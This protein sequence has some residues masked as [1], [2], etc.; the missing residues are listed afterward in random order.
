METPYYKASPVM[1]IPIEV[2]PPNWIKF[3]EKNS[4]IDLI[5]PFVN[6]YNDRSEAFDGEEEMIFESNY[7]HLMGTL[8]VE[9]DFLGSVEDKERSVGDYIGINF[10]CEAE[11]DDGSTSTFPLRG[12]VILRPGNRD[13][14]L[15]FDLSLGPED[16]FLMGLTC[17]INVSFNIVFNEEKIYAD[18]RQVEILR[19]MILQLR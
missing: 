18:D 8:W 17:S 14:I 2:R 16:L 1:T 6:G 11:N 19:L 7:P 13:G 5:D 9:P 10:M 4:K 12:E 15:V 3:G